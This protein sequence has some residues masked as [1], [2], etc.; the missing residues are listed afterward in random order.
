[1]SDVTVYY[2]YTKSPQGDVLVARTE[3]GLTR[4]SF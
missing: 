4:I 1:M 2:S 3:A